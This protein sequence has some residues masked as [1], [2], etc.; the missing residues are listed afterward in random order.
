MP[1]PPRVSIVTLGAYDLVGL[2]AFYA[3]LGWDEAPVSTPGW[4]CF[5]TGGALLTL[6]P[7]DDLS[8]D[9][10]RT[11][12]AMADAGCA[13][14]AFRGFTLAVNVEY[15]E[16]VDESLE[17]AR[18]AG[19]TVLKEPEVAPWGVRSA[20]FADPEGNVWEIA[21]MP[22]SSFDAGGALLLPEA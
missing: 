15:D 3:R 17:V 7:M 13:D 21:C 11:T 10:C 12:P 19:A 14:G 4:A 9:C 16:E 5:E 20:Y 6:F 18:A 2:R 1:L 8:D 22:G